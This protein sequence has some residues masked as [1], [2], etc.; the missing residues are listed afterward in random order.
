MQPAQ[1]NLL[2][3]V[4]QGQNQSFIDTQRSLS[5]VNRRLYDQ[6]RMVAYQG[7][8]FVWRQDPAAPTVASIECKVKTAANTWIT[9]NA[10]VKGKALW[11][12]MQD[13]VLEDNP[14]IAGKWH[15]FKIELS[16]SQTTAKTLLPR[17]GAGALLTVAGL[18]WNIST[19]VMPQHEVETAGP[20]A[21][22]PLPAEEKTA[23]LVGPNSGTKESLIN[24]YQESRAT[25]QSPM[26]NV[27]AGMSGSFF[28][29]LTDSGS[30]EPELADV[31]EDEND[32]PPYDR[33]AY[34][35]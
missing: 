24:A 6:G 30:Q 35:G 9:H 22:K 28:N 26:P 21:G 34:P 32:L 23:V 14:S 18:E 12:R 4:P 8:T 17:D 31:I 25:V 29:L 13:L 19:Y 16:T 15:D 27:P 1:T 5:Q 11:N 33:D 3:T 2:F 20:D 10:F 7:L